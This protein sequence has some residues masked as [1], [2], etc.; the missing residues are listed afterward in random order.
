MG[1]LRYIMSTSNLRLGWAPETLSQTG[2]GGA[3]KVTQ[4]LR[5][6]TGLVEEQAS[7]RAPTQRLTT[8]VTLAPGVSV[9]PSG[10]HRH[11][12]R[13]GHR[14]TYRP[15]LKNITKKFFF[16]SLNPGLRSTGVILV[17]DAAR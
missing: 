3:G 9:L 11:G 14:C 8:A 1:A 17:S 13:L 4:Q 6:H 5:A 2:C 7:F 16:K 10:L 15:T 12:T